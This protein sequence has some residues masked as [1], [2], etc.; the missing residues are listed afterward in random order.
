MVLSNLIVSNGM[1][2][3][4]SLTRHLTTGLMDHIYTVLFYQALS[5]PI[6]KGAVA[7]LRWL[8]NLGSS[9]ETYIR[10]ARSTRPIGLVITT[11]EPCLRRDPGSL[12][13]PVG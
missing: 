13:H 3:M 11:K 1:Y 8:D 5:K 10:S 7:Q 6:M 4:K 9:G 12:L 2:L